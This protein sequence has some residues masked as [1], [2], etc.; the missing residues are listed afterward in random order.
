MKREVCRGLHA[1]TRSEFSAR[2]DAV[3]AESRAVAA[4]KSAHGKAWD[5]IRENVALL[6]IRAESATR[7]KMIFGAGH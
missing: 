6:G 4:R 7:P 5:G 1:V 3:H 2:V